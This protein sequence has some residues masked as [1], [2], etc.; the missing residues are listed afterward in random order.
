MLAYPEFAWIFC[1]ILMGGCKIHVLVRRLCITMDGTVVPVMIS[2]RKMWQLELCNDID[3][4]CY[5]N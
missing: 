4:G 5:D 2:L 3:E 1:I